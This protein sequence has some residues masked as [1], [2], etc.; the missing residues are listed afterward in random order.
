MGMQGMEDPVAVREAAEVEQGVME[1]MKAREGVIGVVEV[2]DAVVSAVEEG[3]FAIAAMAEVRE[4]GGDGTRERLGPLGVLS[5][6]LLW[7]V[8]AWAV[9]N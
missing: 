6:I 9:F 3:A 5:H 8:L 7:A 2:G 4:E 1:A